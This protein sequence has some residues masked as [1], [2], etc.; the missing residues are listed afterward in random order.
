MHSRSRLLVIVVPSLFALACAGESGGP[1]EDEI[2]DDRHAVATTFEGDEVTAVLDEAG[3]SPVLAS[4]GTFVRLG[5]MW[6]HGDPLALEVRTSVDGSAWSAWQAP[7]VV[8]Q[9]AGA[10]VG[11]LDVA[12]GGEA[13][14][15]QYRVVG[16]AAPSFVVL[17]PIDEVL[18]QPSDYSSAEEDVSLQTAAI[19]TPIG[20]VRIHSRSEWGARAPRCSGGTHQP[21]RVTIH[22]TVTP[23]A[24]SMSVPQRLRQIQAFH[25]DVRGWCDIGYNYLVS[26]DG[27]VWR[28]RGARTIGAHVSNANT[29]NVGISFLG[30]FTSSI[31]TAKSQ[32]SAAKLIRRLHEDYPISLNR[33]DIKGHRQYGGTSC[34]GAKLYERIGRIITK[35]KYGC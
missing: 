7:G 34:P 4:E 1:I 27:R 13:A 19:S 24:D 30:T 25:Q 35:S 14:F 16:G 2:D 8:H 31:P 21:T 29:G 20:A 9:E 18:V 11:Y 26:R 17:E 32:C 22:H 12:A 5:V 28:G 3:V 23:N 10:H 33:T 6:D 15:Y